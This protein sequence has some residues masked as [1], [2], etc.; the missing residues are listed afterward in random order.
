[1][2]T[3]SEVTINHRLLSEKMEVDQN[4]EN[5]KKIL[6]KATKYLRN[7]PDGI[8]TASCL[9]IK[10]NDEIFI[11]MDGYDPKYK[12]LN[13]KHLLIWKLIER[14]SKMGFKKFNLNGM[15]S[16]NVENNPYNGLNEFKLGFN[17]LSYEYIG[18]LELI[19]N[20]AL[21]FMYQNT[22]PLRNILK[23]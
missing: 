16:L 5:Y 22:A 12:S 3:N 2:V 7:Y 20:N 1:M 23:R 19:T 10:N 11:L 21:Y 17:A 18:D 15:T 4:F 14:Y 6:V 13:S 9:V 8:V